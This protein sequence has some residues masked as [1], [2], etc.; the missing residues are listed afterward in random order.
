M[1][2]WRQAGAQG[3]PVGGQVGESTR[4]TAR[5][6][7]LGMARAQRT[8][9]AVDRSSAKMLRR[10]GCSDGEGRRAGGWR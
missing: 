1:R 7:R 5:K 8:G 6:T 3:C 2:G 4:S 9:E 10:L